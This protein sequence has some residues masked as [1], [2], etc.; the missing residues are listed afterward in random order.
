M[1][2][3]FQLW[4][5]D[6][7]LRYLGSSDSS[8]D[9]AGIRLPPNKRRLFYTSKHGYS[10]FNTHFVNLSDLFFWFLHELDDTWNLHYGHHSMI[11]KLWAIKFFAFA[12]FQSG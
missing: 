12:L 11:Q 5:E 9:M 1:W 10:H 8:I 4:A 7:H 6:I 3:P 2:D